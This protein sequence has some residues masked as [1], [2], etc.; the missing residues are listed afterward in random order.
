MNRLSLPVISLLCLGSLGVACQVDTDD[1]STSPMQRYEPIGQ[2]IPSDDPVPDAGP[3]R[4]PDADVTLNPTDPRP[5]LELKFTEIPQDSALLRMTDLAFLPDDSGELI[6]VDKDGEVVHMRMTDDGAETLGRFVVEDT[7]TRDDSGLVSV[8]FDPD[9]AENR[10][11]YLGV[12]I[13]KETNVIRRYELL[14]DDY[15]ATAAS[16]TL[17]IE[18]T[19]E[20]APRAWHNVGSIG[21]TE[22]GY[23][24]AIFGDK[25]LDDVAQDPMSL[26]GKVLRIIPEHDEDGGF[27]VPDDNPFNDGSGHPAV[28]ALGLRSPW[29]AAYKDGVLFIGDIGLDTF[30][31]VNRLSAPGENFGWPVHEGPCTEDC[32]Q[33]SDPWVY[34]GRGSSAPFVQD[35]ERATSARLRSVWVAGIYEPREADRYQGLLTDQVLLGDTFSGFVRARPMDGSTPS[36][37]VGHLWLP[38]AMAQGP[39]DYVYAVGLGTWPVDAP[40]RL[41]PIYRAE[42][43]R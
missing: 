18:V 37:H 41:S 24:W 39:D 25:V 29:K 38:T 26:L 1:P 13:S 30:E 21:F 19:G 8:A 10:F 16:E 28:Y 36:V 40:M 7:Y 43:V 12:T 17:V 31:E 42:L 15:E 23:M 33:M 6:V 20:D 14:A 4:I 32:A 2:A 11:F 3:V 9:F 34:Y 27:S 35:D 5:H 22:E